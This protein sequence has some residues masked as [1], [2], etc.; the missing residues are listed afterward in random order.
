MINIQR[1]TDKAYT[2]ELKAITALFTRYIF[3]K[4][5]INYFGIEFVSVQNVNNNVNTIIDYL[6][7]L[8]NYK[9]Y[10]VSKT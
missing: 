2:I 5:R 8:G 3:N 4:E 1:G 10:F 9:G 6:A 7:I